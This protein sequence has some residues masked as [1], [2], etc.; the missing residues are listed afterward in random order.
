MPQ[1]IK[2]SADRGARFASRLKEGSRVEV[3]I[4]VPAAQIAPVAVE[5]FCTTG[6][7]GE[8]Q[9]TVAR[10]L[11]IPSVLSAQ[12]ALTCADDESTEI[13]YAS[14]SLDVLLRCV[15]EDEPATGSIR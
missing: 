3:S 9:G 4:N 15:P 5:G 12:A 6:D 8:Q 14:A 11:T 2:N 10:S 7:D 1:S 13:T